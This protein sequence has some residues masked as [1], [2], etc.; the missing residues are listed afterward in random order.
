M[1]T[2]FTQ[3]LARIAPYFN[4]LLVVVVMILLMLLVRRIKD[5]EEA[6]PWIILTVALAVF[7]VE[8]FFTVL[9]HLDVFHLP[10]YFNS[11]FEMAIISLFIYMVLYKSAHIK[12]SYQQKK[13]GKK[14]KKM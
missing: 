10:V 12:K 9:R 8:E 1:L 14:T 5:K 13:H 3:C 6:H 4:L 7:I 11:I 2:L